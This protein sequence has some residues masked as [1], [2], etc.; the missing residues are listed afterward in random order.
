VIQN[1]AADWA[2]EGPYHTLRVNPWEDATLTHLVESCDN[3]FKQMDISVMEIVL[4][5]AVG[6]LVFDEDTGAECPSRT[7]FKVTLVCGTRADSYDNDED[8]DNELD[9]EL[10]QLF[11]SVPLAVST[12]ADEDTEPHVCNT[13]GNHMND[14]DFQRGK[15]CCDH[16]L[17]HGDHDDEDEQHN[18]EMQLAEQEVS[19]RFN[20]G[21][22]KAQGRHPDTT[23][24]EWDLFCDIL[25]TK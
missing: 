15:M 21:W 18:H 20:H 23:E 1:T 7:Y 3:V 22:T 16:P 10:L 14:N 19:R 13:C 25:D 11:Q 6:V 5:V 24:E 9:P 4:T 8:D 12:Y 17:F 2:D